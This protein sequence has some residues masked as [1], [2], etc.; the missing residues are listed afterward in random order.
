[1]QVITESNTS[2]ATY[3]Y[4]CTQDH[5]A[6]FDYHSKETARADFV[7]IVCINL[8]VNMIGVF[9]NVFCYIVLTRF[10][11]GSQSTMYMLRVLSAIDALFLL[12]TIL[13]TNGP[14]LYRVLN[15]EPSEFVQS[16]Y[17]RAYPHL[18]SFYNVTL[19]WSVWMVVAVTFNR[20]IAMRFPLRAA[21]LLTKRNLT[22]EVCVV[23][24]FGVI[25][26]SGKF[27]QF[28]AK[29]WFDCKTNKTHLG[30][31]LTSWMD[32]HTYWSIF[33]IIFIDTILNLLIP[34]SLV[35]Y[36]NIRLVLILRRAR[37]RMESTKTSGGSPDLTRTL[38]G[39]A[40]VF[41]ICHAPYAILMIIW[42]IHR[43]R[44]IVSESFLHVF[45]MVAECLQCLAS[46]MNIFIYYFATRGFQ[47][48]VWSVLGCQYT[49]YVRSTDNMKLNKF[50]AKAASNS[51]QK[52]TPK[53][54]NV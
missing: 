9:L 2:D 16:T 34:M 18:V 22:I 35:T 31:A 14:S 37:R 39:V 45:L 46:C 44:N 4:N 28:E 13:T 15:S 50:F 41:T 38:I 3:S 49:T 40:T 32:R 48:M 23:I 24:I 36:L 6:I 27:S 21:T 17:A 53:I 29:M 1:M 7:I 10:R 12:V 33:Y 43:I 20:F 30:P 42:N 5:E 19:N 8:P 25:T 54:D 11:G 47:A 26:E 51:P 52:S